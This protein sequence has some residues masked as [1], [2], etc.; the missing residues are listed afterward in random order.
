ML[1]DG[2]EMYNYLFKVGH[3]SNNIQNIYR[4]VWCTLHKF[5]K[6]LKCTPL[7]GEIFSEQIE[8]HYF[9]AE[10]FPYQHF[11]GTLTNNEKVNG[12]AQDLWCLNTKAREMQE[13]SC[14][15]CILQY[16]D[17]Y[18]AEEKATVQVSWFA[19]HDLQ[20]IQPYFWKKA[21]CKYQI[22]LLAT[23]SQRVV[24][25][26]FDPEWASLFWEGHVSFV[27]F[28]PLSF[29]LFRSHGKSF[30]PSIPFLFLLSSLPS[31][32]PRALARAR[33]PSWSRVRFPI[34]PDGMPTTPISD[35]IDYGLILGLRHIMII[36]AGSILHNWHSVHE[37]WL[38]IPDTQI[39]SSRSHDLAWA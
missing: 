12:E 28:F 35:V 15:R 32:S 29:F 8:E 9:G 5:H 1:N 2:W 11:L 18:R 19:I 38:S 6:L 23:S 14:C 13:I 21:M 27:G 22:W 25:V 39:R 30:F 7:N 34:R 31:C 3:Q 33:D 17:I 24:Y 20:F 10:L 26:H 36:R 4:Q 16:V 37:N